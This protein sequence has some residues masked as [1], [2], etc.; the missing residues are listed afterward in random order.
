[1]LK[2]W[3]LV[4]C[5]CLLPAAA[6]AGETAWVQVPELLRPGKLMQLAYTAP[7]GESAAI[8]VVDGAGKTV[9]NL[10]SASSGRFTWDGAGVEPGEYVLRLRC[11]DQTAE[12]AVTVGDPAPVI[13]VVDSPAIA[14][15]GWT[16]RVH[17]SLPGRLTL[18]LDDGRELAE[19][20]AV[21]GDNV[22][23]WNGMVNNRYLPDG[24]RE[25]VFRLTDETGFSSTACV[26]SVLIDN[27]SPAHD[28]SAHSPDSV[29]GIT[30]DHDVCYWKLNMGE[31]DESLVWEVL[32]QPVTVLEGNERNQEKVRRE[33]REDCKDYT[34]EVTYASQAVHVLEKGEEWTLIEAYSSS[35]EGSSVKNFA[36]Q[37]TGY[38]KTSLLKEKT[39]SQHIG[40]VID[41][42]QQ[43]LYVYRDG[44]L[45]STLLCSTGFPRADTP[46]NETPAG[47]YLAI[48]W[49]GGFWSDKLYC[50][51]A[52]RFNDGD[53]LH[54][55]PCLI[56][57][58]EAGRE[59]SRDYD[60]C[61]RFLGEK[62]SHGCIRVQREKSPEGVNMKWLWDNLPRN[63]DEPAKI[64]I[65]DELTRQL[66][67]ADD[68]LT[69]YYNPD[70][71]RQYHS[72]AYCAL[73]NDRFLPLTAFTCG[74]LESAPYS[75]LKRCPGC[76]PPLRR[77]EVDGVNEKNHR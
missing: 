33:P 10:V 71:G 8:S 12:R 55:V 57:Y 13:E 58:D 18:T 5:L 48:R 73:V 20:E 3:M 72:S 16:V 65:W 21:A 45:F 11:G 51:M 9:L 1:M 63:S 19:T 44:S 69:V 24:Q 42:L 6:L 28:V 31:M 54:E 77:S 41:K 38:V 74:E 26:V 61:G 14:V 50:D 25:A 35:V 46:Y 66:A 22:L 37:F 2:R 27:P 76:T 36:G 60:R 70:N 62:A 43:R 75:K 17:C 30:C 4:I 56:D 64:L 52:I 67:P 47:E 29:S 53:L 15:S 68:Q 34:G 39:V 40:V 23:V 59:I 49:T 32:T 7:E